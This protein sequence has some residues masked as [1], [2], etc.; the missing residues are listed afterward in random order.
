VERLPV[1]PEVKKPSAVRALLVLLLAGAVVR[2]ALLWWC[3]GL[4]LPADDARDYDGLATAI[5]ERGEYAFTPGVPT[6]LRPP[7]YPAA[8]AG[9]YALFGVHNYQAV[10]IA[11]AILSLVNVVLVYLLGRE[12]FGPPGLSSSPGASRVGLWAAGIFCFYP[13]LL[14][15]DNLLLTEVLFTFWVTAAVY[16]LTAALNRNSLSLLAVAGVLIGLGALTRS[17]LW[18][19]PPVL[20][21]YLLWAW[22]GSFGRRILAAALPGV[23]C[24]VTI[25]PWAVRNTR[26]QET[27]ITVDCMGGRNFLMGNYEHTPLY[28]SWAVIGLKG[29]KSWIHKV[30]TQTPQSERGSQGRIDKAALRLGLRYV[31]EH[32]G[33]TLQRDVIKFFDFWGVE[34]TIVHGTAE[35]VFGPVPG[36][37]AALVA[38]AVVPSYVAALFAGIFGF[39]LVPPRD[40]NGHIRRAHWLW[41]LLAAFV[42]GVHTLVFAHSRYHLP[43]M[44]LLFLYAGAAIVHAREVWQ[45]RKS[46]AFWLAAAVCL[47]LVAGWTV[48]LVLGDLARMQQLTK[49]QPPTVANAS[50]SGVG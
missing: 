45:R 35:G 38:L 7:L 3:D 5:V 24:A 26:V 12:L 8:V 29:D 18:L 34:R 44:P 9:L 37:V 27:L 15:F 30:V 2:V 46:I 25:A 4:G 47:L 49:V 32:P 19:F 39:L 20:A 6:S 33:Q 16:A 40:E 41:L 13:T 31:A 42:C 48:N 11:Q 10:R 1:G 23:L 28:R 22:R 21:L 14:G 50:G 43:L 17:I 36:W